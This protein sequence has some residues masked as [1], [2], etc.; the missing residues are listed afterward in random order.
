MACLFFCIYLLCYLLW[1]WEDVGVRR[2]AAQR[3]ALENAQARVF[4]ICYEEMLKGKKK[5]RKLPA[6]RRRRGREELPFL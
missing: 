5:G 2:Q 1:A 4:Y 3:R 6:N